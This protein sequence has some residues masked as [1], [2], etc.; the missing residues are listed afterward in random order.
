MAADFAESATGGQNSNG[1]FVFPK[2]KPDHSADLD[3]LCTLE[4]SSPRDEYQIVGIPSRD[5]LQKTSKRLP[6]DMHLFL[7]RLVTYCRGGVASFDEKYE[8]LGK[9]P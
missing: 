4:I 9:Y 7:H 2:D 6:R 3:H 1:L 5:V 8:P